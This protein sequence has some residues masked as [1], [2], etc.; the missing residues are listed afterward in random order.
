MKMKNIFLLAGLAFTSVSTL[1][2]Q[3]KIEV[4]TIWDGTF[5]T[6]QLNA[7]NTLHTKNQYSV[8]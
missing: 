3:Q 4:S 8:F 2:A 6:K 5:R 7:L 1:Q